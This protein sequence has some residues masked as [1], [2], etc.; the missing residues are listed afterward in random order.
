MVLSR[1]QKTTPVDEIWSTACFHIACELRMVLYFFNGWEKNQK[2]SNVFVTLKL[3]EIQISMSINKFYWNTTT[4]IYSFIYILFVTALVLQWYSWKA[5]N[6]YY[7]LLYKICWLPGLGCIQFTLVLRWGN[8]FI[9]I[10]Y[11]FPSQHITL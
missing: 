1:G 7:L 6:I 10:S 3:C 5:E 11:F 4:F 8:Y 9:I 2:K